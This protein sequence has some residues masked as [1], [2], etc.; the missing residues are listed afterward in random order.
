MFAKFKACTALGL[1]ALSLGSCSSNFK[2]AAESGGGNASSRP[3]M[4]I[5]SDGCPRDDNQIIQLAVGDQVQ[6]YQ[7]VAPVDPEDKKLPPDSPLSKKLNLSY[8][9]VLN[10]PH[11]GE[12]CWASTANVEAR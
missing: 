10:G 11:A 1:L 2:D 6:I 12:Y 9:K 8:V 5:A 4:V 3:G 7:S